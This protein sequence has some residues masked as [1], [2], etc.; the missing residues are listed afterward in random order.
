[1]TDCRNLLQMLDPISLAE[2]NSIKLMNRIDTKFI[3]NTNRLGAIL[4][5]ASFSY[6]VQEV[7]GIRLATY[8]TLYY[9]TAQV[10][11]YIRHHDRQLRRQKIRTR[12]YVDSHLSFLEVKNKTNKGRT[13]KKR[14]PIAEN[15]FWDVHQ[16]AES[17]VFLHERSEYAPEELM[18]QV[19]T[20]FNRITLVNREKTE[21]L[22]IDLNLR[23][24]NVVTQ[25]AIELPRLMIIELK[26][27]GY[28]HSDMKEILQTLRIK[29]TKISKYCMGMALTN[30]LVKRNRFKTKIRKIKKISTE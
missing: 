28:A 27:D 5:M 25:Q 6:R 15:V 17:M 18:P 2:M 9:D 22:T 1:M 20:R 19:R 3:A 13:K 4:E 23:F 16:A 8:D 26:Q 14:I 21:R 11:M 7:E 29:P 10:D 12:T 30:S 24:D